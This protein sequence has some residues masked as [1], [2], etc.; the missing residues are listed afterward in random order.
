TLKDNTTGTTTTVLAKTCTNSGA[1]QQASAAATGGHSVTL[2]LSNHDDNYA[3]DPTYTLYDDVAITTGGGGETMPPATTV[4]DPAGGATVSGTVT[5]TATASDNVGVTKI[6]LYA[7][8][9]LLGSGTTSP[10]SASWDT[11]T[12]ANG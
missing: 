9:T 6:E 5:V 7:D 10:A 2:T 8:G 4:T 3:G 1:W 12:A 11:T